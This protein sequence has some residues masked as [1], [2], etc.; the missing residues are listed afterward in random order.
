M[1]YMSSPTG[2]STSASSSRWDDYQSTRCSSSDEDEY[3][4][5]E[6]STSSNSL[7]QGLGKRKKR[8]V[9]HSKT[10]F[11]R[12]WTKKYPCIVAAGED[13]G[14]ALCT[15]CSKSFSVCH[16]GVRDV[17]HHMSGLIQIKESKKLINT[18]KLRLRSYL[19]VLASMR[20]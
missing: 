17:E 14:K 8:R 13:N 19:R 6:K 3:L 15:V 5:E 7:S 12:E 4:T 18:L 20:E 2:A 16:Q 11:N 9:I 1:V 10:R